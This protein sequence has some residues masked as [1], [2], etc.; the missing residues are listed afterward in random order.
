VGGGRALSAPPSPGGIPRVVEAPLALAGL[1]LA[2][3]VI[4]V[5]AAAVAASSGRPVFFRQ[6]RVGRGGRPFT[7]VKF[8]TMRPSEGG[9]QVTAGDDARVTVVGRFLRRSKLDELP[10]LWNVVKGE[11]SLVGPRPEVERYVQKDDPI[12]REVLRARPG[13]TDPVTLSLRDEEG[14]LA[15][16]GG[17]RERYYREVLQPRK[18]AGYRDYLLRRSWRSDVVVIWN[19]L[20]AILWPGWR[21]PGGPETSPRP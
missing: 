8:R 2:S 9:P 21:G 12:W 5:C 6:E 1:L 11:M 17:D 18:L 13:L 7:L 10:E 14:L 19:T 16:V 3:P 20:L 15:G 4:A